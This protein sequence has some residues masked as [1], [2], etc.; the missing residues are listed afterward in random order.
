MS[1]KG[2]KKCGACGKSGHNRRT[3]KKSRPE[4]SDASPRATKGKSGNTIQIA[5]TLIWLQSAEGMSEEAR[6]PTQKDLV[7]MTGISQPTVSRA[8]KDMEAN[9]LIDVWGTPGGPERARRYTVPDMDVLRTHFHGEDSK[10]P[11]SE[12]FWQTLAL[13]DHSMT[14]LENAHKALAKVRGRMWSKH[15][16]DVE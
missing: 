12:D 16:S 7:E 3:C 8:V 9:G 10:T 4:A 13:V 2:T 14:L 11:G 1:K 15:A 6:T 5:E